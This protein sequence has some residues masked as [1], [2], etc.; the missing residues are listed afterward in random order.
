MGIEIVTKILSG[1]VAKSEINAW[2]LATVVN[3][4]S[5]L[6]WLHF[7]NYYAHIKSRAA[8]KVNTS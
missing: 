5:W 4:L 2:N 7:I 1:L 6:Q 8:L 3:D